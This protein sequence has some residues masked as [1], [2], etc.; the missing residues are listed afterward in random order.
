[1][2]PIKAIALAIFGLL[3]ALLG[4][5]WFLQGIAAIQVCPLLCVADCECHSGGSIVYALLGALCLAGG[6]TLL[7]T[8]VRSRIRAS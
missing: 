1:M 4:G 3:L 5:L 8:A 7:L 6:L 2:G